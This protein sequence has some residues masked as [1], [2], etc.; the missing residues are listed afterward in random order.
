MSAFLNAYAIDT[1]AKYALLIDE[2]TGDVLYQKN[3]DLK[4]A[5]SSM[6]KLMTIYVAF[7][8]LKD[9]SLKMDD[10]VVVSK[11]AWSKAGSRMFLS[12]NQEVSVEDLIKG[13]IIQSGNDATIALAEC[14]A[15]SEEAF[16][17]RMNV[18][19]KQMGL[20]NSHFVNA[21][22]W[23]DKAHY[24]SSRDLATLARRLIQDYPEYYSYFG[25]KEF[26]FNGIK[27][28]NR[29][30][31]LKM[32]IGADGL[33]TGHTD[34]AGYGIT[35]SAKQGNRRVIVV[36]NGLKSDASRAE[37]A[38]KLLQYGFL[39]FTNITIAKANET[40]GSAKVL[41]GVKESVDLVC[42]RNLVFTVPAEEKD[43]IQVIAS[44]DSTLSAPVSA[45]TKVGMV[46]VRIPTQETKIFDIVTKESVEKAGWLR[47][48]YYRFRDWILSLI[49]SPSGEELN[50]RAV[51]NLAIR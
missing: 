35:A 20:Q 44:Y 5:P 50:S 46:E 51:K 24:M 38:K 2:D 1:K 43:S 45:G 32:A 31:L 42:D 22:G 41:F 8:R 19:A 48:T 39:N 33:K 17:D 36:V 3:A 11:K 29:N 40:I 23:P 25:E 14:I 30:S 21:T 49:F 13:I 7:S 15:G 16:A 28:D 34:A 12:L 47:K 9:G 10:K 4:M 6:S 18:V 37:E 26:V 27:Q